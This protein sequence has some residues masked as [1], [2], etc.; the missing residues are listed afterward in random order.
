MGMCYFEAFVSEKCSFAR[1][2]GFV[3]FLWM[4]NQFMLKEECLGPG[5]NEF[6]KY[7]RQDCCCNVSEGKPMAA[8]KFFCYTLVFKLFKVSWHAHPSMNK[9]K[10]LILHRLCYRGRFSLDNII[11]GQWVI[12]VINAGMS[13]LLYLIKLTSVMMTK[14][15]PVGSKIVTLVKYWYL[16][17]M[18]RWIFVNPSYYLGQYHSISYG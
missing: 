11:S 7:S 6:T 16:V 5:M 14:N 13:M 2:M 4:P 18:S 3:I 10:L 1:N 12:L 9:K 15:L 17:G 8:G